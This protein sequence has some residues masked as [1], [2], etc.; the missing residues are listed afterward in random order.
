MKKAESPQE[1]DDSVSN[2]DNDDA[3]DHGN[4]TL[5]TRKHHAYSVSVANVENDLWRPCGTTI[6]GIHS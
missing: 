4:S 5:N 2:N 3:T 1:K 6:S